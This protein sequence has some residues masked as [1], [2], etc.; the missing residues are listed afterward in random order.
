MN[1]NNFSTY[2]LTQYLYTFL[3]YYYK[4]KKENEKCKRMEHRI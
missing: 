1:I 2:F 3:I 4:E